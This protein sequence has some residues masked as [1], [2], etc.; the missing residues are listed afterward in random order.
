MI[1][2]SARVRHFLIMQ[3]IGKICGQVTGAV[4]AEQ[5]RPMLDVAQRKTGALQGKSSVSV[6]SCAVMPVQS[7]QATIWREKSSITVDR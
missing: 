4:V 3:I 6:T 7:R 1:R 2:P 5:S